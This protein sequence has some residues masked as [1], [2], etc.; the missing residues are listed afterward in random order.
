MNPLN[1]AVAVLAA[2]A[3]S[4]P[5][6]AQAQQAQH[7]FMGAPPVPAPQVLIPEDGGW[8]MR[9]METPNC[10][11]QS[12]YISG[13]IKRIC[14]RVPVWYNTRTGEIRPVNP[15][16]ASPVHQGVPAPQQ[17]APASQQAAPAPQQAAPAP[18][19]VVTPGQVFRTLREGAA[20]VDAFRRFIQRF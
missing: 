9:N 13:R 1:H 11:V 15:N 17:A 2:V 14:E 16:Q 5:A 3:L 19:Q 10:R 20:T 8:V 6:T 18:K 7:P 4:T 12:G